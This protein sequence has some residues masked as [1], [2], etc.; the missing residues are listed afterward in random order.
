MRWNVDGFRTDFQGNLQKVPTVQ[1]QNRPAI[2]V[3]VPNGF[4]F[5]GEQFCG[6]KAG[7]QNHAVHLAHFSILFIDGTDLARD[8]KTGLPAACQGA[9]AQPQIVLQRVQSILC[10]N[11]LFLQFLPPRRMGKIPCTQN[12][13]S[14]TPCPIIQLFRRQVL[15]GRPGI[16]GMNM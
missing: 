2:G 3:D 9:V 5:P 7:Q 4:Q 1:A 10:R 11:Q 13:N 15:A 14:L 8:D 6:L 16:P 12:L